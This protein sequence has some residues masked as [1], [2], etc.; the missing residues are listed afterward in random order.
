MAEEEAEETDKI[1]IPVTQDTSTS[2]LPPAAAH[3]HTTRRT[4]GSSRQ[5]QEINSTIKATLQ[6]TTFCGN[7]PVISE[8]KTQQ[9]EGTYLTSC[10]FLLSILII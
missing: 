5:G 7:I 1:I 8:E 10:Y 2:S 3:R 4:A 9:K 6:L